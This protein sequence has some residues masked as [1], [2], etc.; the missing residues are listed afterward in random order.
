[1]RILVTGASGFIGGHLAERFLHLDHD[2]VAL[3]NFDPYYTTDLKEHNVERCRDAAA[4]ADGEFELV[5]GSILDESLVKEVVSDVDVIYHQAAQ[6]G[7]RTSI[8]NPDKTNEVNVNGTLTVLN[9]ARDEG[10]ERVVVASSSSVYGETEYL[11]FDEL[12][13]TRPTSPYGVSKLAA[14]QYARVYSRVYDVDTIVLRYFT[15]YG[16]RMRPNMA[17]S[18]FVSRCANGE[19][20]IIYGDGQQTRDFTYIDDIVRVNE[21]FLKSDFNGGVFNIGSSDNISVQRLA[22]TIRDQLAP[23]LAIRYTDANTGDAQHT[24]ADISKAAEVLDYE[25]KIDI[26]RGV[27]K[28]IDW[29]RSERDWYEPLVYE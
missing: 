20:P 8:E 25:P 5:R 28:F 27:S 14:E 23:E 29:Y 11:P 12:H 19:P 9:A 15:V 16:P 26:E 7:V 17:I 21:E 6:A 24:H 1:M 10:V 2:V 4:T 3:D 18:N 22:E 13:P